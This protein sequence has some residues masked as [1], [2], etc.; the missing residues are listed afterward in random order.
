MMKNKY[1]F[2]ILSFEKE[3]SKLIE[4]IKN[5]EENAVYIL[6]FELPNTNA[7]DLARKIRKYDW[8]SP[9]I[10]LTAHAG[11][12]FETFKQ[13]LQILD[14]VAKQ[15]QSEKNL[16]E[17][18]EICM[19]QLGIS[20][21]LKVSYNYTNY[22]IPYDKILYIYRDTIERKVIVVTVGAEY[23][24]R[25][26]MKAVK[27]LLPRTFKYSHRACIINTLKVEA[28]DWKNF[29]IYFGDGKKTN[30]LSKTHKKEL[31]PE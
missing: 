29:E 6:D 31:M 24:V 21:S 28:Y 1:E 25:M 5:N 23:R 12:A 13:R 20:K 17:L 4:F 30:L 10:I 2:G 9:I 18:F 14:F 19:K 27:Q 11:M 3:T 16:F 26:T 7:I 15:Y 22:N 8:R